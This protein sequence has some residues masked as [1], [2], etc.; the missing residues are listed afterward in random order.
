MSS[1]YK[2]FAAATIGSSIRKAVYHLTN[3]W[4]QNLHDGTSRLPPYSPVCE[5]IQQTLFNRLDI[6]RDGG[7]S[8]ETVLTQPLKRGHWLPETLAGLD[9]RIDPTAPSCPAEIPS[10]LVQSTTLS[11]LVKRNYRSPGFFIPDQDTCRDKEE[12][13]RP[14][15]LLS[16]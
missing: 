1:L 6:P 7:S 12:L 14:S 16:S 8:R 3:R 5:D 13:L 11:R 2:L 9:I 10:C 15:H 4:C